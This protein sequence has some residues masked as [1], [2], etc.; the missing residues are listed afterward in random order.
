MFTFS[1]LMVFS[2]PPVFP[3]VCVGYEI[4]FRVPDVG[5]QG[6][7][8]PLPSS[9]LT[10]RS[11]ESIKNMFFLPFHS[12]AFVQC[13]FFFSFKFDGNEKKR[14]MNRGERAILMLG[15]DATTRERERATVSVDSLF[16]YLGALLASFFY[17]YLVYKYFISPPLKI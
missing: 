10:E 11:I 2:P 5:Q 14:L 3:P 1:A 12:R 7:A 6:R 15:A 13:S 8:H 16:L 9:Q 17:Y 4:T